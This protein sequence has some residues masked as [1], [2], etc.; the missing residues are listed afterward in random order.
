MKI[1]NLNKIYFPE[2]GLTN[3]Y[4]V[5]Y[6]ISIAGY[7]LPYLKGR[8]ESLLRHP[9]GIRRESFFQK[10]AAENA[11][12]FVT[13]QKIYSE[14]ND[15]EINYQMTKEPLLVRSGRLDKYIAVDRLYPAIALALDGNISIFR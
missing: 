9:N 6:Y 7:I 13:N 12:S 4:V 15:K 1:S 3:G 10:D 5:D 8:P 14:S 2:E 11:P